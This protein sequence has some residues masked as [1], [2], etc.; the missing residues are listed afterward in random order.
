MVREKGKA[1][2]KS[3]LRRLLPEADLSRKGKDL[4]EFQ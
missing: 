3:M 1:E 2:K 4:E